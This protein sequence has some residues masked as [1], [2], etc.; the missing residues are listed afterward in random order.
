MFLKKVGIMLNSL[1][2]M[3]TSQGFM[4]GDQFTKER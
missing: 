1:K 2:R 3:R 4:E